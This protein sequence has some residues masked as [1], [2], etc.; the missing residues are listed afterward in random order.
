MEIHMQLV[1]QLRNSGATSPRSHTVSW[2]TEEKPRPWFYFEAMDVKNTVVWGVTP[3][4]LVHEN[5]R[6]AGQKSRQ[7]Y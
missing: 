6:F 7:C 3:C 2:S 1:S 4:G 5:S